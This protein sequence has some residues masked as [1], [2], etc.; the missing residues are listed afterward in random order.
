MFEEFSITGKNLVPLDDPVTPQLNKLVSQEIYFSVIGDDIF[1]SS[2]LEKIILLHKELGNSVSICDELARS[3]LLSGLV[4]PPFT[5]YNNI[6]RMP[7]YSKFTESNGSFKLK[8]DASSLAADPFGNEAEIFENL[9]KIIKADLKKVEPS[10]IVCT[11]S[12]GADSAVLLSLLVADSPTEKIDALCCEMPGLKAEVN[13]AAEIAK[14]C[15]VNFVKYR[16]MLIN[17]ATVIDDYAR[18]YKNLV[19]DPV[20]PVISTMLHEYT[21]KNELHSNIKIC[22]VEGQ[23][24]DTILIGLPHAF[25]LAVYGLGLSSLFR[26]LSRVF[27]EPT[28]DI[29]GRSR[30]F[31]RIIKSIHLLS[32]KTWQESILHSLGLNQLK[33]TDYYSCYLEMIDH[34]FMVT[35]DRQKALVLFF[36]QVISTREMQKYQMLSKNVIPILPFLDQEFVAR[37][38]ASRTDMFFRFPFRKIPIFSKVKTLYGDIFKSRKTFPFVVEYG[39]DKITDEL[40]LPVIQDDLSFRKYCLNILSKKINLEK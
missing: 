5:I 20:V 31:Y 8:L 29:R 40:G 12:G 34:Y 17:P 35:K 24:A 27:P 2:S 13:K 18:E 10:S 26:I 25:T 19:F 9:R 15:D 39:S 28:D 6:Y 33:G 37:C 21:T 7:V 11:L 38:L 23:G 14:V 36:L 32:A 3:Y 22:L 4:V 1:L 16:P 30:T